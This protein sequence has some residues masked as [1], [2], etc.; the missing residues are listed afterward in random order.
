M[1]KQSYGS[2]AVLSVSKLTC[3]YVV[4]H[5]II[6][7]LSFD[8]PQGEIVCLLGPNGVGKTT[9]FKTILG[10]LKPQHGSITIQGKDASQYSHKEFAQA[11]A[12]VPQNH[13]PPF[14][15]QVIDV[16]VMGCNPGMS[17]FS[18]PKEKEYNHAREILQSMGI[19]HLETRDY[20]EL[21]GGERQM[22]II[23]RALAQNASILMMDEPTAYLDYGNE[24]LV[25]DQIKKLSAQG[26]TIIMITHMP[27]HAFL[28]ADKV[29]AVG[30]DNYFIIGQPE[31]VLTQETLYKLYGI[32]VQLE[33][34]VLT[35][36]RHVKM[37]IQVI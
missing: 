22:V 2:G 13:I 15:Y 17:E 1:K 7:P 30:M 34:V 12:Y 19:A 3:G 36:H 35:N 18:S 8:I 33:D 5:P 31:I 25:L 28:C 29:I 26:Y 9:L 32:H 10:L 4:D 37:C 16:V 27:N 24:V 11:I 23:A 6:G 20:T 21:S 14:D